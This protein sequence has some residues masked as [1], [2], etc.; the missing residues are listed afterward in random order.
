MQ[1]LPGRDHAVRHHVRSRECA[2]E[3]DDQAFHAGIGQHQIERHLGLGVGLAADFE[4]IR[5]PAAE[6]V[7][8]VHR[9]HGQTGAVG[10]NADIAVELDELEARVEAPRASSTVIFAGDATLASSGCRASAASSSDELAIQR[11]DLAVR[12]GW[13]AD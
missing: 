10:E 2:A 7:D 6:M 1:L 5:R 13:R 12:A 8:D 4:E 3:I 9:R 11:H